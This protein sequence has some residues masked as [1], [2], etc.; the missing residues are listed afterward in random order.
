[1]TIKIT[2]AESQVMDVLWRAEGPMAAE[3]VREQ[4]EEEWSE[5]TVRTFLARLVK[6][7]ACAQ[8]KDGK[9]YLYRPL[10][11]RADYAREESRGLLNRLFDGE[12]GPF[13]TQ[14]A[15]AKSLSA[16]DIARLK[17]IVEQFEDDQ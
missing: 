9:R 17:A 7:K 8:I 14:F 2:D 13:V 11:D 3:A 16:D 12:I 10:L 5:A 15:Q 6:K 4:L 1:M